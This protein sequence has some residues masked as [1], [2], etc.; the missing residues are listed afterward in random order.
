MAGT[1]EAPRR[2]HVADRAA[3][4]H[5]A[6]GERDHVVVLDLDRPVDFGVVL[7]YVRQGPS[8]LPD[9]RLDR[10]HHRYV[11]RGAEARERT[12]VLPRAGCA[13]K[14]RGDCKS[15]RR[16][17]EG[18]HRDRARRVGR[19]GHEATACD[20]FAFK[21]TGDPTLLSCSRA[22]VSVGIGRS[23]AGGSELLR[24]SVL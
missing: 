7:A 10:D 12:D 15:E 9:A 16:Q 6:R 17:G 13:M 8:S 18:R 5:A 3:H 22:A 23:H 24:R 2:G 14:H 21:G 11:I 4:V 1:D 20:R 19:T